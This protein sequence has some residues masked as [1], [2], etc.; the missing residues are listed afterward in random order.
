MYQKTGKSLYVYTDADWA[1]NQDDRKSCSGN[2]H[3]LTGGPVSWF[4][5]KQTS[6]ALSTME[7]EYIALSEAT[8]ETIHL[9]R[10]IKEMYGDKYVCNPTVIL[11]DNQSAIILSKENMLHKRSKHIETRC[12]F[13]REA[14]NE[15]IIDVKFIST[16]E[17]AADILTKPLLKFKHLSCVRTLNLT[18]N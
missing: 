13:S 12:H 17:N 8:K 15:G 9:R 18:C 1:G 16:D 11:C 7:A 10:L 6:V 14:Q 3:I 5:K 2:V 4:S